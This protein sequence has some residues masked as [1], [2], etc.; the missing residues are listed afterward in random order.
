MPSP[1]GP[2][3]ILTF[4]FLTPNILKHWSIHRCLKIHRCW[5]FG[6]I[7]SSNFQDI[8]LTRPKSENDFTGFFNFKERRHVGHQRDLELWPFDPKT[9]AFMLAPKCT[10]AESLVLICP[11]GTLGCT[12]RRTGSQTH[13]QPENIMPLAALCWRRN[14]KL[15]L[16]YKLT[17]QFIIFI[18]ITIIT[19]QPHSSLFHKPAASSPTLNFFW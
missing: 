15:Q 1:A 5:K 16:I 3:V 11:I 2:L 14:K 6:E 17:C 13:A 4:H 19:H 12:D 10:N 7:Q 9:Y 18:F 8:A